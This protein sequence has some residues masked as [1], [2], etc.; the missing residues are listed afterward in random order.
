MI[1]FKFEVLS[2][3]IFRN[4]VVLVTTSHGWDHRR[5]R[6]KWWARER[7]FSIFGKPR[8]DPPTANLDLTLGAIFLQFFQDVL[9]FVLCLGASECQLGLFG[10]ASYSTKEIQLPALQALPPQL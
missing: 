5:Y 6:L 2:S 8:R 10:D 3:Q 7:V 1:R 9:T 4:I